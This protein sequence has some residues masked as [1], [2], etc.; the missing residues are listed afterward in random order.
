[1]VQAPNPVI[2][3]QLAEQQEREE[4]EEQ[5]AENLL[6]AAQNLPPL[7]VQKIP[8]SPRLGAAVF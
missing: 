5:A 7:P 4:R 6:E 3:E 2:V 1:M 8:V